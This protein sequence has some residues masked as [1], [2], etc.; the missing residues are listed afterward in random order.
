MNCKNYEPVEAHTSCKGCEYEGGGGGGCIDCEK[1]D[2]WTLA[3]PDPPAPDI[4]KGVWLHSAWS[5]QWWQWDSGL[6]CKADTV[7]VDGEKFV[8]QGVPDGFCQRNCAYFALARRLV[9]AFTVTEVMDLR[10]EAQ[11]LHPETKGE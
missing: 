1:Y 5:G 11:R 2:H 10:D 8:R 7:M 3:P 4:S 9:R 6:E